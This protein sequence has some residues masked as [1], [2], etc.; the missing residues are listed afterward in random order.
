[1]YQLHSFLWV[2]PLRPFAG[3]QPTALQL[4]AL[5]IGH[6]AHVVHIYVVHI[7]AHKRPLVF[8]H[9]TPPIY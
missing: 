2:S 7:S 1:M 9:T 5:L 6:G 8:R 4:L 3:T